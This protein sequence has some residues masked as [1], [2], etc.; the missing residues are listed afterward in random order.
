MDDLL[1][2]IAGA[3]FGVV[4][5]A[6][7]IALWWVARQ[8]VLPARSPTPTPAARPAPAAWL[9]CEDGPALERAAAWYPLRT[10]G[11]TVFG[12]QPRPPA[13][14]THYYYLSAHDIARD[15]LVVRWQPE[16]A[17]YAAIAGSGADVRHN[18]EPLSPGTAV[19][20]ADGDLLDLG[21]RIRFRFSLTG[22]PSR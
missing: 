7:A 17:R 9:Y 3:T 10:G 2:W 11:R 1:V 5:M 15:H 18:H 6:T 19:L 16:S 20:L 12:S 22:P 13:E 21:E 8:P 4:A 14:E